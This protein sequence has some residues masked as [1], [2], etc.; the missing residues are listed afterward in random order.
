L[1]RDVNDQPGAFEASE[2]LADRRPTDAQ[3]LAELT[4]NETV[5]RAKVAGE[6]RLA[7]T[8]FD[9]GAYGSR[10]ARNGE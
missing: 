10:S 1:W 4:F 3:K 2:R 8:T 7:Q 9:L 5:S 6:N